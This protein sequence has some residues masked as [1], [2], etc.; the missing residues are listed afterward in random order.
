MYVIPRLCW[1]DAS[2]PI[3]LL[4]PKDWVVSIEVGEHIDQAFEDTFFDNLV[5]LSEK[6]VVLSWAVEGQGGFQHVNEQSNAQL[7]H[8]YVYCKMNN[9]FA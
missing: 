8:Y 7:F 5:K 3:D 9:W 2:Q 6:G 1:I 4:E